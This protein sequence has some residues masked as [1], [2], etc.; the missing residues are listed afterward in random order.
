MTLPDFNK[1]FI[2]YADS[3][4]FAIGYVLG[5]MVEGKEHVIHYGGR[6][7]N[8]C[9]RNYAIGD[10]EALAVVSA[11]KYFHHYL[12][13]KKFKIFTDNT[14]VS[15]LLSLKNPKGR[16]A[17]YL[18]YLQSFDFELIYKPGNTHGNADGISRITNMKTIAAVTNCVTE[19]QT[20][21]GAQGNDLLLKPMIKYL[22]TGDHKELPKNGKGQFN[23]P[24]ISY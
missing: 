8:K 19:K 24:K 18:L 20:W 5:Q 9:E 3:S 17:R 14:S 6:S 2:V 13:S 15:Y 16:L 23:Q 7:L 21:L 12:T 1:E 4:A 10:L 22:Q 11:V